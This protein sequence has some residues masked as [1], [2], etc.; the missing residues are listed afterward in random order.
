MGTSS[1]KQVKENKLSMA[2]KTGVLNLSDM[3]LKP[4]SNV[5]TKLNESQYVEKLKSLDLS[6]N[7]IV[8][9]PS[10]VPSFRQLKTLIVNHAKLRSIPDISPLSKLSS[11]QLENNELQSNMIGN[12]PMSLKTVKMS[13]NRLVELPP[14]VSILSSVTVLDLSHNQLLHITGIES[15]VALVELKLSHN[16][17]Q[18]LPEALGSLQH[19]QLLFV[20]YNQIHGKSPTTNE[21]SIPASIFLGTRLERLELGGN[22]LKKYELSEFTG[23]DRYLER[24]KALGDKL[25]QGGIIKIEGDL[26]GLSD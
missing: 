19:L 14:P 26:C 7:T 22:P 4:S 10:C 2:E 23:L 8:E 20:E 18:E 9:L 5:W 17:L 25:F 11:I 13:H 12:L 24:R 1:S 3:K 6:N 16:Q 21:Q 15:M